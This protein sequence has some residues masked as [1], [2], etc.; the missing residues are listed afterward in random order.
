MD[1]QKV[2]CLKYYNEKMKGKKYIKINNK[3]VS[4]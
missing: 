4:V 1:K 3:N 2:K